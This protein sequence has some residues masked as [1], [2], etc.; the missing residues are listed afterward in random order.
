MSQLEDVQ[1]PVKRPDRFYIN[2]EWVSP[3]SSSSEIDVVDSGTE[4]IYFRTPIAAAEDMSRAVAAA[5]QAFDEG[6]W[7]R[8]THAERA[9]QLFAIATELRRRSDD[10]GQIW[11]RQSGVL[12][13]IAQGVSARGAAAYEYYGGLAAS[14]PFEERTDPTAGGAFGLLRHEPVGV[15]G[16]IV[17]WNS[18][19]IVL[20]YKVAPALLAGCT[21][22]VKASPEA[23][24]EALVLAEIADAVGIPPGVINVVTADREISELLVT[25]ARVDK[26]SFTGSTRAGQ[27][28]AT[29]LGDRIARYTLELGGKS[30]AVILD[31]ADIDTTAET[32]ANA[33]C[34]LTGQV[35]SSLTRVIV[36]QEQHQDLV[37]AL[38]ASFSRVQVGSPFDSA[39]EMGPLATRSQRERVEGHISTAV[40]DGAVLVTGGGRPDHLSR[41]FYVEPTV[42]DR[43]DN[44]SRLA[45][46][47]VFGPVLS[48]IVAKDE[49]HAIHLANQ[50]IYGLNASVFTAD[51]DRA[52]DVAGKL[53]TGTVGHNAFRTDFGMAFGGFKQSGVGREGGKV[54]LLPYLETKAVILNEVPRGRA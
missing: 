24:G 39:S 27:R 52:L 26:I 7:P 34:Y 50:S 33:E 44:S 18:P 41:G 20:A 40:D 36:G 1:I 8:L 23:P 21:V 31:D 13:S 49:R 17:P 12:N 43:V 2:G 10:L 38:A 30:A 47:E 22:V 16:A 3:S 51:V 48:V 9:H 6:P 15:V 45:Q 54:G 4:M 32:L 42:F 28:I 35:C 29:L 5:R 25:D 37:D 46:E 11:T 53:R 14:Y 19:L